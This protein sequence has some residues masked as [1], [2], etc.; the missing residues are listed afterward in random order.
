MK[1][2]EIMTSEVI[3]C[4]RGTNLAE[5]ATRLWD[6]DCG[7][8]PVVDDDGKV[9]GLI[10]DRDICIAVI[11]KNKL[12]SEIAVGEVISGNAVFSC[13]ADEDINQALRAMRQHQV[14]RLPVTGADETLEGILS[15][16]DVVLAAENEQGQGVSFEDAMMTLKAICKHQHDLPQ[17]AARV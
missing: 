8:L 5:A 6:N 17:K 12:A 13:A 9:V 2:S 14:R 4:Q 15:I 7:V 16:N 10:S 11:T 1:I 3:T